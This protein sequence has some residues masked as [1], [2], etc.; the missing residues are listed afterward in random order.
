MYVA[1]GC[2]E[3]ERKG[4]ESICISQGKQTEHISYYILHKLVYHHKF[5]YGGNAHNKTGTTF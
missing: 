2:W 4:K 3:F 5:T 1:S